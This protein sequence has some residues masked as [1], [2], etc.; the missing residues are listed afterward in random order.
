MNKTRLISPH[1]IHKSYPVRMNLNL[2][3]CN[4]NMDRRMEISKT[5]SFEN[6]MRNKNKQ[7][8]NCVT[9]K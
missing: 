4:T 6:K 1:W 2:M 9:E 5:M 7:T 3:L 8:A